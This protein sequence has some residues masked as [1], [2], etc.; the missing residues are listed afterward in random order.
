MLRFI[1]IYMA[2]HIGVVS[3]IRVVRNSQNQRESIAYTVM[4]VVIESEMIFMVTSDYIV[5]QQICGW[6]A[7][8][9]YDIRTAR[10]I[11]NDTK[12]ILSHR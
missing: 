12:S 9:P 10:Y 5:C 7:P 2:T 11:T 6:D 1:P 8:N 3:S 4:R